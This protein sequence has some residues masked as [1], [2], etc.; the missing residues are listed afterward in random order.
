MVGR[1]GG[2]ASTFDCALYHSAATPF[3]AWMQCGISLR[4]MAGWVIYPASHRAAGYRR[5][6]DVRVS[7]DTGG[8]HAARDGKTRRE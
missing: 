4:P 7:T 1:D 2:G 6:G 5:G 8:S 3:L